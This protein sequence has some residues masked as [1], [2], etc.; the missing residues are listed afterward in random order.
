MRIIDCDQRSPE[1]VTARLGRLT[2]SRASDMLATLKGGGEGAGRRNLRAALVLERLTGKSQ[3]SGFVSA[4]M[5]AG[6]DREPDALLW[7]EAI[8]GQIVQR[9]GF[10]AHDDLLAG[11][12]LDGHIG[13]FEGLVEAKSPIPATHL[14]YLRTGIVPK[15]YRDQVTHQLWITGAQWCDWCSFNPDFPESLRCKIVRILRD[16]AVI[17]EYEQKALAF[18]SEVDRDLAAVLAMVQRAAVA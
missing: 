6:I 10:I 12:S 1:W 9:T 16:D 8:S 3:E 18:L 14:E 5:Q 17:A 4:A 2:A 11:A 7:Y 13:D 15:D